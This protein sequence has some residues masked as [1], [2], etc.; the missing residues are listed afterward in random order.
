M[1][2]QKKYVCPNCGGQNEYTSNFCIYCGGSLHNT[3]NTTPSQNNINQGTQVNPNYSG[4]K[5]IQ[6]E[7]KET[8]LGFLGWVG[9]IYLGYITLAS[10]N[11]VLYA[12]AGVV[13]YFYLLVPNTKKGFN[14]VFKVIGAIVLF[15]ILSFL[16]LLGVCLGMFAG[17]S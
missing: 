6:K 12:I 1:D 11:L 13:L 16:V 3:Q 2:E 5:E 17:L 4:S 14:V 8:K 10:A 15:G 9:L 7:K